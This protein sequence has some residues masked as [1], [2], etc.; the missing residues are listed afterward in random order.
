MTNRDVELMT[1]GGTTLNP[2]KQTPEAMSEELSR[3]LDLYTRME[4]ALPA[5]TSA[6]V[7]QN[8]FQGPQQPERTLGTSSP[9]SS[10]NL[11]SNFLQ[12]RK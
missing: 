7:N 10:G 12:S 1:A 8:M 4:A 5:G 2:E 3:V 9:V 6:Q 11:F